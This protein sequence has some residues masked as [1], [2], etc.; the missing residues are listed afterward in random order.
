MSLKFDTL[1]VLTIKNERVSVIIRTRR[2]FTSVSNST[3]VVVVKI[4]SDATTSF[5]AAGIANPVK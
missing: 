3:L 1:M 4:T 5:A 2:G